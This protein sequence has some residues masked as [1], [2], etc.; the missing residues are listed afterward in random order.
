MRGTP[1]SMLA[2]LA[3]LDAAKGSGHSGGGGGGEGTSLL[4]H[5]FG[6][7]VNL[8]RDLHPQLSTLLLIVVF[9]A[10]IA[11]FVVV[12][13]VLCTAR[14]FVHRAERQSRRAARAPSVSAASTSRR[15]RFLTGRHRTASSSHVRPGGA[16]LHESGR[17]Y[18]ESQSIWEELGRFDEA[19]AR[20]ND[21][22]LLRMSWLLSQA[23]AGKPLPRRQDITDPAAFISA[24]ELRKE[25]EAFE[26]RPRSMLRGGG[27]E[28]LLPIV[29][30]SYTWLSH[31]E[32]DPKAHTLKAVARVL[33]SQRRLYRRFGVREVGVFF[34]WCSTEAHTSAHILPWLLGARRVSLWRVHCGVCP[35]CGAGA[36][37]ISRTPMDSLRATSSHHSNEPWREWPSFTR[38][39]SQRL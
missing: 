32:P 9:G 29:T 15:A 14:A 24:R 36:P 4:D 19:D 37:C 11:I 22:A 23:E 28:P 10:M 1:S 5:F 25:Y 38:T 21:V 33:T 7:L 27:A 16:Q 3:A 13:C 35:V 6:P 31:S 34:D 30:L 2:F 20:K 12:P 18:V 39:S 17:K 26:T 8:F